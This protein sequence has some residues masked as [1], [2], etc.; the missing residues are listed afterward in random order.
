[1]EHKRRNVFFTAVKISVSLAI[2]LLFAYFISLMS[3]FA[4]FFDKSAKAN[5]VRDVRE[6]MA[7]VTALFEAHYSNLYDLAEELVYAE[8]KAEVD[9][10]LKPHIGTDMF[11]DIRYFAQGI[12]YAANGLPVTNDEAGIIQALNSST[13]PVCTDLYFDEAVSMDCV[14]LYIP[15]KGSAYIDGLVGILPARGCISLEGMLNG[16]ASVLAFISEDGMVMAES[17]EGTFTHSIGNNFYDFIKKITN[18]ADYFAEV[19]EAVASD[20]V[21]SGIIT[22]SGVQYVYATGEIGGTDG[23]FSIVTLSPATRMTETELDYVSHLIYVL[24]L[25]I[26]FL[27]VSLVYTVMFQHKAK[28]EQKNAALHDATLECANEEAFRRRCIEIQSET[29]STKHVIFTMQIRQFHFVQ[30]KLGQDKCTEVLKFTA[31]VINNFCNEHETFGYAGDGTFLLCHSYRNEANLKNRIQ[32]LIAIINKCGVL[33][34]FNTSIA[35]HIGVCFDFGIKKRTMREIIDCAYVATE[36]AKNKPHIP[37][38]IYDESVNQEIIR[39]EQL[40][41]EM[42][43]ALE[44]ADF[45]VFMQPKYDIKQDKI[46][47]A[48]ALV[49]WFDKKKN[50]YRFP[51]EFIDLFESNGFI[52]KLDHFVFVEVCKYMQAAAAHRDPIVPVSVNVSRV[53]AIQDDFINFYV[54]N[55]QK[56]NIPDGFLTL[57]FTESFAMEDYD[58]IYRIVNRLHANGI[59]CSID[60]FGSGYSSFNILKSIQMDELKLDR[61][62][63]EKGVDETRDSKLLMTVINLAKSLGMTVV[64][65]GVETRE[66]YEK[67]A[68]MGCDALQGYYYAKALPLEE[69]KVFVTTNTSIK[70]KSR[71]K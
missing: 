22:I 23:K 25:A 41:S 28:Q 27:L 18:N 19:R 56:Y 46:H 43:E 42:E 5:A 20:G 68:A 54:G 35:F 4:P 59:H 62:F 1:M 53:T 15:V 7:G 52:I 33:T 3:G 50:D 40:E 30:G 60:D 11:G 45:K 64:Q 24:I 51:G 26:I 55:K 9:K 65:E 10:T 2:F 14:A 70:Y 21:H 12:E 38:V 67:I 39:Q 57:E 6:D 61:F 32:V 49:R 31:D 44:G 71:V 29:P 58:T 8:S 34:E 47:S 16:N 13:R 48:E 17:K 63:L 36:S 37:Y 69:Y 66:M